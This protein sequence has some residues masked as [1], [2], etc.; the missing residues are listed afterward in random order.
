MRCS[1][2]SMGCGRVKPNRNNCPCMKPAAWKLSEFH[3]MLAHPSLSII[4]LYFPTG[5]T[6]SSDASSEP[7]LKRTLVSVDVITR[8]VQVTQC[9]EKTGHLAAKVTAFRSA[10]KC[11]TKNQ[12]EFWGIS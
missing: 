10:S 3:K 11:Y 1:A 5:T 6:Y 7:I 8:T 9:D 2:R 12:L 4:D